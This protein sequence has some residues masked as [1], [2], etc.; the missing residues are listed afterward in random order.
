MALV[1]LLFSVL[2]SGAT[3]TASG[4]VGEFAKTAG[5]TAFD[6]LKTRLTERHKVRSLPLLE[7]AKQNPAFKAA[8]E[9]ELSKPEIAQ[10]AKLL[11][12]AEALR[13]EIA[14]LPQ[15]VTARYAVNIETIR[16][17]GNL[18]F[19]AV[20]GIKATMVSSEGDMTLRDIKAPPG[21]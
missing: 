4:A 16:S 19:E 18:L 1:E 11:E 5:K 13:Q 12:L 20:E 2:A 14:A 21:K 15:E 3:L 8:I 17:G 7:D 10:D 6:A 9:A